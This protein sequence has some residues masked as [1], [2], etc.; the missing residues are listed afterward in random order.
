MRVK[1]VAAF[2]AMWASSTMLNIAV[3]LRNIYRFRRICHT[4]SHV[5]CVS[6]SCKVLQQATRS[7]GRSALLFRCSIPYSSWSSCCKRVTVP[8]TRSFYSLV[9]HDLH[10]HI[11]YLRSL[12][13]YTAAG[14]A[15]VLDTVLSLASRSR[16]SNDRQRLLQETG[17]TGSARHAAGT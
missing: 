1:G 9:L 3:L 11:L 13:G 17:L 7:Y 15:L 14:V 16:S 5:L 6:E 12:T 8:A 10:L 4:H 2:A